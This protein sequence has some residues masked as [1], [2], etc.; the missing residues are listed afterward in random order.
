MLVLF[1]QDS[2]SSFFPQVL[3]GLSPNRMSLGPEM[4]VFEVE[5]YGLSLLC[6]CGRGKT[7]TPMSPWNW[8]GESVEMF[9]ERILLR[10]RNCV[11]ALS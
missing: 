9:H 8:N 1:V 11:R 5:A 10:L 7:R 4:Y 2:S 3:N 6:N